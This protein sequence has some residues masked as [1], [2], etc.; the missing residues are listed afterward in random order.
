[1]INLSSLSLSPCSQFKA[2]C[3]VMHFT[4]LF[5]FQNQQFN[6]KSFINIPLIL[7]CCLLRISFDPVFFTLRILE[8]TSY[9]LFLYTI[10]RSPCYIIDLPYFKIHVIYP[11][12]LACY[13]RAF[14]ETFI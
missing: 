5:A 3:S 12:E 7:S 14:S 2:M 6:V 4:I 8:M 1:M 11:F 9:F 10:I 13:V